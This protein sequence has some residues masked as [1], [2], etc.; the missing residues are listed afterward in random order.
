MLIIDARESV[1][2]HN[3]AALEMFGLPVLT[4]IRRLGMADE[5]RFGNEMMDFF[6]FRM[7]KSVKILY[8]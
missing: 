7:R 3:A 4:H 2:Q 1:Y 5:R 6:D 8:I